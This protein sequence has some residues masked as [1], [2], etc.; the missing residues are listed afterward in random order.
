MLLVVE[1]A[2]VFA[3][4]VER[5]QEM[6]LLVQEVRVAQE[7]VLDVKQ[8]EQEVL[9][10]ILKL[11]ETADLLDVVLV[12]VLNVAEQAFV[13][14]VQVEQGEVAALV[15]QQ[16]EEKVEL[17]R[18]LALKQSEQVLGLGVLDAQQVQA[19]FYVQM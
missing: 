3:V 11:V 13:F 17:E 15:L 14:A 2:F 8:D 7:Q 19:L 16:D 1:Q 12:L 4:Q 9:A 5:V 10:L 6:V 18:A